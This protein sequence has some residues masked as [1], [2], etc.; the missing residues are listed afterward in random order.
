M[1]TVRI[2]ERVAF[3]IYGDNYFIYGDFG[4]VS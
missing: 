4:N 1:V 2:E 3:P